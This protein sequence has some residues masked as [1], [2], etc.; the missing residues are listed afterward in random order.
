MTGSASPPCAAASR[1]ACLESRF[2]LAEAPQRHQ[3]VGHGEAARYREH[4]VAHGPHV[5]HPR[6]HGLQVGFEVTRRPMGEAQGDRSLGA[7]EQ[8]VLGD[9]RQGQLGEPHHRV[10]VALHLGVV[11]AHQGDAS[12]QGPQLVTP[13][14][15]NGQSVLGV[16]QVGLA[17]HRVAGIGV[18]RTQ[19]EAQTGTGANGRIGQPAH[20]SEP[21]GS[22]KTVV[23][24]R[25]G[26][27]SHARRP[28]EVLSREGM[29]EGLGHVA[30]GFVPGA[31]AKVIGSRTPEAGRGAGAAGRRT[32]GGSGTSD[33][34]RRGAR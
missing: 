18:G 1:M 25:P 23:H 4:V 12:R 30:V 3:C 7:A 31:G 34:R 33:A 21:G 19:L 2:S 14:G 11:G 29:R 15:R 5:V 26:R 16:A 9:E 28:V 22:L 13:L 8:I 10:R 20:P 27:F 32:G 24:V 6:A 17:R